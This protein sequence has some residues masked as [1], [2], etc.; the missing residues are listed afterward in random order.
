MKP[1]DAIIEQNREIRTI[2]RGRLFR[3]YFLLILGLVCG[4]LLISGAIG[5]YFSYQENKVALSSVQREKAIGAAARIEQFIRQI[6]QQLTFAALPQLGAEGIEQRRIEFLKLLRLVP[7]VTDIAQ[8]DSNGHE[9]LAVSRLAMDVAGADKDRSQD[10]AVKGAKPG[11]TWFGPVYFRKETEP[12]ISIAVRSGGDA[13]AVT[14]AEVNLKFIWDVVTRIKI[15]KKGKAYVVDGS[16]HLVADP[17]IGLVLRK[18]DLS[19][20]SQVKFALRKDAEDSLALVA[21]DLAGGAVLTAYGS[22]D[23]LGWK[24]FV[25][26][27]VSEV[28]ETLNATIIRTISLI[29]A[30]LLISALAAMWL[31]RSMVRPIRT[32][33]EGAARI[34]AGNLDQRIEISTGD[35]LQALAEQFNQMTVQLRE[36]YA[37]LERKVE[38]RTAELQETLA[39]QRASTGILGIIASSVKDT[40]PVF[41]AIARAAAGVLANARVQLFLVEEGKLHHVGGTGLTDEQQEKLRGLY[42]AP[43]AQT[44][45]AGKAILEKRIV[46]VADVQADRDRSELS[47]AITE[48][49]GLR[50]IL[51][52]PMIREGAAIGCIT[53]SFTEPGAFTDK[54][55]ALL[56]SF[57]DQ[58]VIAIQNSRL[59]NETNESLEQQTATSEILRVISSSPTDVQP[60]FEAIAKS[61]L[62]LFEDANV[63][64]VLR[65]GDTIRAAAIS[66]REPERLAKWKAAFPT[67]LT[68]D[69][70]N[71]TAIL[72]NAIVDIPDVD[73]LAGP[74]KPGTANF[75][76]TGYKAVTITPMMRGEEAIGAIGV[77]RLKPGPLSDKQIALLKTF[78]DQAVIAIENVRLFNETKEALEQQ[79]A[80]AEVLG[81][82]SSSI[83][84]TKPVFDKILES[85]ERL[86][87][88]H[89]VG[90]TL[91]TDDG[92]IDLVAYHG[93]D[94]EKLKA[95]YPLPLTHESGS[96]SAI[97]D[98]AVKH[99]P[100]AEAPGTPSGVRDGC[101]VSGMRSILFAPMLYEGSGIGAIWVGRRSV[102]QF[103][104]K[105]IALLKT[106]ADQAVIAIQNVRLFREIQEKSR[107]L[108][109]ANQH[110]SDFLANMSHELRTPLN[111]IIGFSEVLIEKMFGELNE[112]Q[113]DY[114]KDIH[115]SGRHLLSL[116]ND[117]LDLAKIEAGRMELEPSD[118]DLPSALSN[119]MTLVRERAQRHGIALGLNLDPNLSTLRADERKFK[120]IVV[121]LLS[122]AV[123]FTSDGGRVDVSAKLANDS[124]EI[125]VADTGIG[126]AP[127]DQA[128]VFEEFKQV[129]RDYT[130][131]AEGTGLGLALTKRF[132]ELHG[133]AIRL[134]SALGKGSTFTFTIPVC[135]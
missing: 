110:K 41:D 36:S 50:A 115:E 40:H 34:G 55:I 84:D 48:S 123:K 10:P 87:E 26:Q 77:A 5:L 99:Y 105:Q 124:V 69:Y 2:E 107:Q 102:S 100:D 35:E 133:G 61:G 75:A 37:G 98:A 57:S 79:K 3:K 62:H 14:V 119:A 86:F 64:V 51:V 59:F 49:T 70:L 60:V 68:R 13:G 129:G 32:L 19:K 117:I 134:E 53:T 103:T 42:P 4:A 113:A 27:P 71:A 76:A 97:L 15:G 25:E 24:V 126:I 6:E 45:Y 30:G 56:K 111:A 89:L 90:V 80:S 93:A 125:A 46:H 74:L 21:Q 9:L 18:T 118:F 120:Q 58:A 114:M 101:R 108:E 83:A 91:A 28:Y 65:D 78:A 29:V 85:C 66:E 11:Q 81:A 16:G 88:G 47:K 38:E 20:L 63:W 121:N 116:I 31:A 104:D 128:A 8:I 109:I 131:K 54:Q 82:I 72:D 112:K 106:F 95:V 132:V 44:S 130:R 1:V 92:K 67:P 127:E 17:D 7:A 23:P 73:G 135:E 33:Q 94:Y 52:V 12:Y 39:H 22:I 96:G 43:L 122:N